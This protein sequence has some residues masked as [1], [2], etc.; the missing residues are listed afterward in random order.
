VRGTN[1]TSAA[2]SDNFKHFLK[3]LYAREWVVYCK[4]PFSGPETVVVYLGRYTHRVAITD[5]RIV[6]MEEGR[7][8]CLWKD[9]N[10]R[11]VMTLDAC[12]FIRRFLL[13]CSLTALS[14]TVLWH[15]KQQEQKGMS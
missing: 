13:M 5:H 12:E 11:K 10:A 4:P 3:C 9:G 6:S 1:F 7:V 2:L 15:L 14:R 8:S